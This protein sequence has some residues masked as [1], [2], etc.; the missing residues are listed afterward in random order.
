MQLHLSAKP[1]V[2]CL[3]HTTQGPTRCSGQFSSRSW[4]ALHDRSVRHRCS[5][6]QSRCSKPQLS[7]KTAGSAGAD[8]PVEASV[9]GGGKGFSDDGAGGGDDDH[10]G[11]SGG[12]GGGPEALLLALNRSLESLPSDIANGIKSG[13]VSAELLQKYLDLE[14]NIVLRFFL[15]FAGMRER[16]LGD[17]GFP[18]KLS[19]EVGI[20]IT[21]KLLAEIS[22]RGDS[23]S[24]E[25]DL[26][27]ANVVMALI[28]D[29]MLVWLPAPRASLSNQPSRGNQSAIGK[30]L[31]SCPDNAFQVVP[32]GH[33]GYTIGQR[34]G[35][36]LRN[37]GKLLGVGF[38][39]SLFGVG[40]TNALTG[41][42]QMLDPDFQPLNKPQGVLVTSAAYG[43]FMGWNSNLRY[44]LIAGL[45][46]QR[47]I[48]KVF[49]GNQ[50]VCGLL[51]LAVRT[52]N[53]F[54]GSSMWI[55][56]LRLI[57]LQKSPADH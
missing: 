14:K 13:T 41:I 30:W 31:K 27:F 18:V 40:L 38:G 35:A 9:G 44:Q 47:G 22:K 34:T 7:C 45:V 54:L 50:A 8:R 23:F 28:A 26:V 1:P 37:G 42:K 25:L 19:I 46:E 32:A 4:F 2:R 52:G 3:L 12:G 5:L 29:T 57:G 36:V 39:S 6:N 48:E 53:T 49:H 17:P 15:R 11:G 20:G 24:S 21:M 33:S 51:S 56:Y 10:S 16:L 43:S 55:D